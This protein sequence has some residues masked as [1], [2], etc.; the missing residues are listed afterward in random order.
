MRIC[1]MD[2]DR[3]GLRAP[4]HGLPVQELHYLQQDTVRT[5]RTIYSGAVRC[6]IFEIQAGFLAVAVSSLTDTL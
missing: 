1:H 2:R 6:H 3:E 4:Q 5:V